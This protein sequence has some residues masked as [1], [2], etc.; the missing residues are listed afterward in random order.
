MP[1]NETQRDTDSGTIMKIV[2]SDEIEINEDNNE[3][4]V[5]GGWKRTVSYTCDASSQFDYASSSINLYDDVSS[6]DSC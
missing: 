1:G 3:D 6:M 5:D 4:S 2:A